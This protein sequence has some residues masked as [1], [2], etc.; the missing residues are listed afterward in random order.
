MRVLESDFEIPVTLCK[1][2]I[3]LEVLA[4]Q[5]LVELTYQAG[6]NSVFLRMLPAAGKINID[7]SPMLC[8]IRNAKIK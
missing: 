7:K 3:I 2:K 4:E 5:G 6:G 8:K 1:F